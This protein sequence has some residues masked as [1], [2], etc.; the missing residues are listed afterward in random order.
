MSAAL[1]VK[2]FFIKYVDRQTILYMFIFLSI[3]GLL[4]IPTSYSIKEKRDALAHHEIETLQD[5]YSISVES[6]RKVALLLYTEIICRPELLYL[7]SQANTT[8]EEQQNQVRQH[9]FSALQNTYQ[10]LINFDLRQLHFHLP[11]GTS[12][13]RF[14]RPEKF[15]DN[16]FSSRYSIMLANTQKKPIYGFEEG[17]IFNG[18]R[19]VFPLFYEG[20]HIGSVETSVGFPAI[21]TLMSQVVPS[22]L[23]FFLKK[24]VIFDSTFKDE[25]NNYHSVELSDDYL[26]ENT[27]Q[28]SKISA[29]WLSKI[30]L[31]LRSKIKEQLEKEESFFVNATVH[32]RNHTV[33]F[34]PIQNTQQQKVAYLAAY[35]Q[36]DEI[37]KL[38]NNFYQ[39]YAE[40]SLINIFI[41]AFFIL[42]NSSRNRIARKNNSLFLLNQEKNELMGIVAHDLK[43]PLS[44]IRGYAEEL[45]HEASQMTLEEIQLFATKIESTSNRM[46]ALITNLL[47]VKA[48]ESGKIKTIIQTIALNKTL[49]ECVSRYREYAQQKNINLTFL[50][51]DCFVETDSQLFQQVMDNLISNAIKYSQPQTTVQV[52]MCFFENKIRCIVEDQGPGLSAED[53]ARLFDKFSRLTPIPTAGEHST[54][55]GLFIVKKLVEILQGHI[56]CESE[57]GQG[58]RFIVEFK[59]L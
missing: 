38:E 59:G 48:I 2:Y 54:G 49:A 22:E 36:S 9:L 47:D 32:G 37:A 34:I 1:R 58:S 50:E 51:V 33:V 55:L 57:L 8:D 35:T 25:Q 52:K 6:Y 39:Q 56:W 5:A 29:A 15:G 44:A 4:L 14:H 17:R 45:K 23:A 24:R 43:N 13:L 46:F 28:H 16:L 30:N 42:L 12:F 31:Q 19:Y 26:E 20:K 27:T 11:D 41:C 7:M 40:Y 10:S 18:F 3:Q 21:E 53:Q